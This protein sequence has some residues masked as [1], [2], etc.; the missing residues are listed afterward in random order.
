MSQFGGV[1]P[2]SGFVFRIDR[3]RGPQRYAKWRAPDGRQVKRRIGPAW[4]G[5]GRPDPGFF[6]KR[7]AEEWLRAA[8]DQA[9]DR[10]ARGV[11]AD[12]CGGL[13]LDADHDGVRVDAVLLHGLGGFRRLQSGD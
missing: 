12:A 7:T 2:A 11:D 6:T 10:A 3:V 13:R 8:L 9:D 1:G 5:R 4:T